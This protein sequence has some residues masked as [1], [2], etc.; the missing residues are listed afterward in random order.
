VKKRLDEEKLT[1]QAR[2]HTV[3]FGKPLQLGN[4]KI[5]FLRVTHSIPDSAAVAVHTPYPIFIR[6][7]SNVPYAFDFFIFD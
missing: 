2:L 6:L 5:E 7:V 3:E 4:V 1:S